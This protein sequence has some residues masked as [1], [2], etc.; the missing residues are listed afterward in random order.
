MRNRYRRNLDP[1]WTVAR[2]NSKDKQG[3]PVK[4]GTKIFY[5]PA[6]RTVLQGEIAERA[7]RDFESSNFDE[8][9]Y[10]S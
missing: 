8:M 1:Y 9:Q 7:S 4:K 6:T 10:N 5:Y 2:F 3:N